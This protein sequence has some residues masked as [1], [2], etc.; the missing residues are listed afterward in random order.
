MRVLLP[1]IRSAI[2]QRVSLALMTGA[3]LHCS[4]AQSVSGSTSEFTLSKVINFPLLLLTVL[5]T[6]YI[7]LIPTRAL[8]RLCFRRPM[9]VGSVTA[10]LLV[11]AT[12]S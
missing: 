6:A 5:H 1:P 10:L 3:T 2:P 4:V 11:L 9:A 12:V 7:L 8:I